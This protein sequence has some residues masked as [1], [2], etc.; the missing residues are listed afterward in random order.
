MSSPRA[1]PHRPR[2]VL[3]SCQPGSSSSAGLPRPPQLQSPPQATGDGS[4]VP[5]KRRVGGEQESVKCPGA[6]RPCGELSHW[7]LSCSPAEALRAPGNKVNK[8]N[9][10]EEDRDSV[11]HLPAALGQAPSTGH[12]RARPRAAARAP[13]ASPSQNSAPSRPPPPT[14]VSMG[15]APGS[16][17]SCLWLSRHP[18]SLSRAEAKGRL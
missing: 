1:R 10:V 6:E 2:H 17:H 18:C 9:I 8:P 3:G 16:P 11:S 15:L 13:R 7:L 14:R 4:A 5:P 12:G